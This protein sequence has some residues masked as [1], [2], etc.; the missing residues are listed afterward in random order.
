MSRSNRTLQVS[1]TQALV[2]GRTLLLLM[3][4]FA[5]AQQLARRLILKDGSYQLA[6]KWEVKGERVRYLSAERNEW[7]EVPNSMADWAATDQ[8]EKDRAAGKA[9]PEA[10]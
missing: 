1:I 2:T 4:T 5:P 9:A 10:R 7:E 6:A 3:T 8:F